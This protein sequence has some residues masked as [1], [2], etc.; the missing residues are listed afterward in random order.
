MAFKGKE[1]P[2]KNTRTWVKNEK[3]IAKNPV[4]RN[5][6]DKAEGFKPSSGITTGVNDQQYKDGYDKIDWNSNKDKPK[7][8]FRV[9]INGVYQDEEE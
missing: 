5:A 1:P 4:L 6:R 3:L 7:P 2:E 8:K 9:K